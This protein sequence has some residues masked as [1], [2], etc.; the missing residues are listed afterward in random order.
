MWGLGGLR[1]HVFETTGAWSMIRG[2]GC[3]GTFDGQTLWGVSRTAFCISYALSHVLKIA[4]GRYRMCSSA[5]RGMSNW[6]TVHMMIV[7][8]SMRSQYRLDAQLSGPLFAMASSRWDA[9]SSTS[10]LTAATSYSRKTLSKSTR[11]PLS[12][13]SD[14]KTFK[15]NT[16]SEVSQILGVLAILLLCDTYY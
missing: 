9:N 14:R 5:M 13:Q 10:S 6:K 1:A 16:H 15:M 4:F 11:D 3:Q 7:S 8:C 12:N 2:V